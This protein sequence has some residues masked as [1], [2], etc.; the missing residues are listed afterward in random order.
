[1]NIHHGSIRKYTS[2]IID[3]FNEV[4]VQYGMSTGELQTKKVPLSYSL[5]E[6]SRV[7]DDY[8]TTQLLSGNYNVLPRGSLAFTSL[9]KHNTRIQNKNLKVNKFVSDT[10]VEYSYNSIAYDFNFD[11]VYQCRGM[12]EATQIIEQVAPMFNPTINIDIWD[13][14]NLSEPTRVPVILADIGIEGEEYDELSSNFITITFSLILT[15]NLY[16]PIK[17]LARINE[18]NIY[19]N[20]IKNDTEATKDEMLSFD[21]DQEGNV[22]P[23]AGSDTLPIPE[24]VLPVLPGL[25]MFTGY[26]GGFIVTWDNTNGFTDITSWPYYTGAP[27]YNN[28]VVGAS[29]FNGNEFLEAGYY[30]M[31]TWGNSLSVVGQISFTADFVTWTNIGRAFDAQ[32]DLAKDFTI[33][34]DGTMIAVYHNFILTSTDGVTWTKTA[35]TLVGFNQSISYNG[36]IYVIGGSTGVAYS[37][38]LSTWNIGTGDLVRSVYDIRWN[39]ST[40][41]FTLTTNWTENKCYYSADGMVWTSV[42]V[43]VNINRFKAFYD[44]DTYSIAVDING[45]IYTNQTGSWTANNNLTSVETNCYGSKYIDGLGFTFVCWNDIWYSTDLITFTRHATDGRNS[46]SSASIIHAPTDSL[47]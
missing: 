29:Y 12:N 38:D 35:V 30:T 2:S 36:S 28:A 37:T 10:S 6:K 24:A 27:S 41:R 23:N 39:K 11:L 43:A 25:A 15:G 9:S 1:M 18:F 14:Q 16:Q 42:Q 40:S 45:L 47:A 22:L 44:V 20:N 32:S 34:E 3:I 21:V 5:K 17:S 8:T 33:T 46:P 7:F 26:Y 31:A 19:M 13:A 4:E